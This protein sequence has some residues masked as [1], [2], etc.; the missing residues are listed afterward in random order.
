MESFAQALTTTLTLRA[1]C[2]ISGFGAS[3][4]ASRWRAH[5]YFCGTSAPCSDASLPRRYAAADR[6]CNGSLPCTLE[7]SGSV[8][9]AKSTYSMNY[10]TTISNAWKGCTSFFYTKCF[11]LCHVDAS[12]S[13]ERMLPSP[14]LRRPLPLPSRRRRR[15]R[16]ASLAR[17]LP[18]SSRHSKIPRSAS[19]GPLQP[20]LCQ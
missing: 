14:A 19:F 11:Y 20:T 17:P 5:L 10:T 6:P 16:Q 13:Q 18:Q 2:S 12:E 1:S 15:R 8:A 4:N 7:P 9:Y 3:S